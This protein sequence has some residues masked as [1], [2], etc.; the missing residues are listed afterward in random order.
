MWLI[1]AIRTPGSYPAWLWVAPWSQATLDD[2]RDA[3]EIVQA[4]RR[5]D[6][7]EEIV[8]QRLA[9]P[10]PKPPEPKPLRHS[11][12]PPGRARVRAKWQI[13]GDFS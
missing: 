8:V 2:A 9:I 5:R 13:V 4:I 6:G 12:I 11:V 1:A 10:Q 3:G 7:H